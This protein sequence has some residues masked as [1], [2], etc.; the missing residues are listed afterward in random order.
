[1]SFFNFYSNKNLKRLSQITQIAQIRGFVLGLKH[2]DYADNADMFIQIRSK[3][4]P[5]D[6]TDNTEFIL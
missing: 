3:K 1:M 6:Y 4:A 5:T 2:A